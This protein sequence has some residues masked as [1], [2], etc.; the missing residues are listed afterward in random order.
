MEV[1]LLR[2]PRLW[3]TLPEENNWVAVAEI[4]QMDV[5]M[6]VGFCASRGR[7][8]PTELTLDSL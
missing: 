2:P 6:L 4:A 7:K 5:K 1:Y 3:Y 8:Q